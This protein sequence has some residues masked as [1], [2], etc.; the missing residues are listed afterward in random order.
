M[1]GSPGWPE[2][3]RIRLRLHSG[4]SLFYSPVDESMGE[5]QTR[6]GRGGDPKIVNCNR[7]RA[8]SPDASAMDP[9]G[10]L[11]TRWSRSLVCKSDVC[12]EGLVVEKGG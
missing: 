5:N 11:S 6:I 12:A 8:T 4:F 9:K 7:K 3:P 1:A 10:A 2:E